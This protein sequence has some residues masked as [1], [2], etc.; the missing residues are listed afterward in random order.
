MDFCWNFSL[1]NEGQLKMF[2]VFG[3]FKNNSTFSPWDLNSIWRRFWEAFGSELL[4]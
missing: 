3:K 1:F 4:I 2:F